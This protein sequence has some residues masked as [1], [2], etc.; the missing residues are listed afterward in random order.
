M[1]I[2]NYTTQVPAD[3][4]INQIQEALV[5]NGATGFLF[6]YEQGTGKISTL[7]F[8]LPIGENNVL[9][10][11]PVNWRNFQEVLR[12]DRVKRWNDNDFCYRVAWRCIRDWV[13][14]QLALH[15]TNIVEL[16]QV[17]LPFAN[18]R[19]GQTLYEKVLTSPMLLGDGK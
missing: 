7:K 6:E 11:L 17:F 8:R 4:S 18:D 9:F 15:Q 1:P 3:R 13:L 12:K 16:P 14:A 2:K 19:S 10:S 5:K